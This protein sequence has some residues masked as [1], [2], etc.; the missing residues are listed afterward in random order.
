MQ[1]FGALRRQEDGP[2][3]CNDYLAQG[4]TPPSYLF[5]SNTPALHPT[6]G[7]DPFEH[8][9]ASL[10]SD[11][12]AGELS[13]VWRERICEWCYQVVDHFDYSREVV[14]VA[15]SFLDRYLSVKRVNKKIFQLAAM[16]SLYLAIKITEPSILKISSLIGLSRG[17]FTSEHIIAMEQSILRTLSWH[18]SPPIV[19][20]LV[21]TFFELL[22]QEV[23]DNAKRDCLELTRFLSE[24]S[25]CDYFFVDKK[26]S[27][28]ALAC[29]LTAF[30]VHECRLRLRDIYQRG[31]Y[32]KPK[33]D[34]F[35]DRMS[36]GRSPD[37]VMRRSNGGTDSV[38]RE[39]Y[40][41]H[42]VQVSSTLV[43]DYPS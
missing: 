5:P 43:N 33:E 42:V 25:V 16:T 3:R 12:S 17:F 34:V 22:P 19:M 27:N 9:F 21:R 18:T 15:M 29:I 14:A 26:P 36:G 11:P 20:E 28:V 37:N 32:H 39:Q 7:V 31:Q 24:L 2:Y 30:E 6:N 23:T 38:Q 1:R 13:A 40:N 8:I 4:V 41:N 35:D 10:P